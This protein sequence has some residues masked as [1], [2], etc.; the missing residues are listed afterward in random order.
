MASNQLFQQSEVVRKKAFPIWMEADFD[1]LS[2][3]IMKGEEERVGERDYRIP[4]QQTFGGRAGH[5]DPQ[6]G[7]MGRGS[8]PTGNV[9]LQSFYSFRLNF[10]F[11]EMQ[12]AATENKSVAIQNPFTKCVAE[13]MREMNLIWDKVIHNSGTAFLAQANAFSNTSGFTVYTMTNVFG[14]QLLRRG[15][16]YNVYDSTGNTLRAAGLLAVQVNTQ[17]RTLTLNAIVPGAT[18]TDQIAF[19]GVTGAQPAGP[20]GLSY[21]INA[22]Q[23][24]ITAGIDRSLEYQIIPKS[25]DG[26]NGFTVE[27]VMALYHRILSDRGMVPNLLG[28]CNTAQQAYAYS[29]MVAIQLPL[30]EGEKANVFDRL[31]KLKGKK[32]FMWGDIPWWIDIHC[33]QDQAF[34]IVPSDWGRAILSPDGFYETPGQSG[35]NARFIQLLGTSGGPQ[36]SVWFGFCRNQDLYTFNPGEQGLIYNLPLGALYQ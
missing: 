26:T 20:R 21:W 13:G 23:S 5:F 18:A 17:A 9:L 36:A 32:F 11:D 3:F 12:I 35:P 2:D 33:R 27:T 28:I 1:V 15:Q 29:Q 31:P 10:E 30:I 34:A 19:E 22:N 24:G 4:F 25:V 8:S 7:D 14:T 16:F 6:G